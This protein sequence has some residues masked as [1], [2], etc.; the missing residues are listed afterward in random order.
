MKVKIITDFLRPG[1]S[2]Q[3]VN[4][5]KS[6]F[7]NK[8]IEVAALN[9]ISSSYNEWVEN[10]EVLSVSYKLAL[11]GS[12]DDDTLYIGWELSPSICRYLKE[13]NFRF[14]SLGVSPIRLFEDFD[15]YVVSNLNEKQ[16]LEWDEYMEQKKKQFNLLNIEKTIPSRKYSHSDIYIFEQLPLDAA[17]IKNSQFM[18]SSDLVENFKLNSFYVIGHPHSRQRGSNMLREPMLAYTLLKNELK[19]KMYTFS[20]S[21]QY[22]SQLFDNENKVISMHDYYA[23]YRDIADFYLIDSMGLSLITGND[24]SN[25]KIKDILNV[26]WW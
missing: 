17:S 21:L 6:L 7:F 4:K 24:R 26:K 5:I 25:M 8:N 20:S 14:M 12:L 11:S 13:K 23:Q 16:G 2:V 1:D 10:F 19:S 3:A 22:E 15:L 9:L 18:G